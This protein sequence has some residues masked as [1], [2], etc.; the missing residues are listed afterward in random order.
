MWHACPHA[1]SLHRFSFYFS[2][3]EHPLTPRIASY[4]VHPHVVVIFLGLLWWFLLVWF[5]IF[6]Y[7]YPL[8]F[9]LALFSFSIYSEWN[10]WW[11]LG[12][13]TDLHGNWVWAALPLGVLYAWCSIWALFF[14]VGV[15]LVPLSSGM[16]FRG[17]F[18]MCAPCSAYAPSLASI[19]F[20]CDFQGFAFCRCSMLSACPFSCLCFPLVWFSGVYF[21][22]VC[23]A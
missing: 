8:V 12:S 23:H 9:I 7:T 20:W 19:A 18:P 15:T 17:S 5:L 10:Q 16:N 14:L 1:L 13:S 2:Q 11:L 22:S 6:S 3:S 4:I 21:L